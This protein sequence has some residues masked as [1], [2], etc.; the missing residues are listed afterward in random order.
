MKILKINILHA[1][2]NLNKYRK[3]S[4]ERIQIMFLSLSLIINYFTL[5]FKLNTKHWNK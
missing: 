2:I 3:K 4:N 1:H 5:I